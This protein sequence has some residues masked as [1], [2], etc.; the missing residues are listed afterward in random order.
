ML[1]YLLKLWLLFGKTTTLYRDMYHESAE[2]IYNIM[3]QKLPKK[4]MFYIAE[5]N[6]GK[7]IHKHDHLACFT[8]GMLALGA[9]HSDKPEIR[10][11]LMIQP[12]PPLV[13]KFR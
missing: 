10:Y 6:N 7:K 8:G 12:N 1:R 11:V 2:A 3:G 4:D 5:Y 9:I 13:I